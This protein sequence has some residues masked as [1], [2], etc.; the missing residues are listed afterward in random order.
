MCKQPSLTGPSAAPCG[1]NIRSKVLFSMVNTD[2]SN[3]KSGLQI[4]HS[5]G[6]ISNS[7]FRGN[8]NAL[9]CH[10]NSSI[11][12]QGRVFFIENMQDPVGFS[13]IHFQNSVAYFDGY[14]LVYNN[15]GGKFGAVIAQNSTLYFEHVSQTYFVQN[16]GFYGG[17]MTM[18]LHSIL[19][20]AS[21]ATKIVF[22]DNHAWKSG[23]AV[24][25]DKFTYNHPHITLT[26]KYQ[27][28]FYPTNRQAKS[29]ILLQ[30]Y[31]C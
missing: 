8:K 23:G 16:Q 21:S 10:S 26:R 5:K 17:A 27:C 30:Q 29:F 6:V 24:Y 28:F 3:S 18:F 11:R 2:I 19:N 13:A 9:H 4:F 12:F 1:I 22:N 25:I 20:I 31:I 14:T 15:R 7:T